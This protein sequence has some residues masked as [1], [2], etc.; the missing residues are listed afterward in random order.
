MSIDSVSVFCFDFDSVR[1]LQC[2][3]GLRVGGQGYYSLG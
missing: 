1:A 3:V 2:V